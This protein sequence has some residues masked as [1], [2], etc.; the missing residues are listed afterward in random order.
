[1]LTAKTFLNIPGY[2]QPKEGSQRDYYRSIRVLEPTIWWINYSEID[3][4]P[5]DEL[6]DLDE[7]KLVKYLSEIGAEVLDIEYILRK[8]KHTPREKRKLKFRILDFKIWSETEL[9]DMYYVSIGTPDTKLTANTPLKVYCSCPDFRYTFSYVLY[10]H[11]ALLYEEEFPDIF[12]KVPP[13]IRNPFQIPF[14]CK[15]VYTVL[16]H[17]YKHPSKY[18]FNEE[19]FYRYNRRKTKHIRPPLG[20]IAYIQEIQE[21]IKKKYKEYLR[22]LKNLYKN[23]LGTKS[24]KKSK[25]KRGR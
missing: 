20:L 13:K 16:W 8:I 12:K 2:F 22:T 14:A 24:K 11:K 9:T 23:V 25:T 18:R 19:S 4:M 3:L 17:L 6:Y 5:E 15:H 10:K 21:T 7:E 1:M